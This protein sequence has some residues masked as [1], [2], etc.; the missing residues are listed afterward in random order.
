MLPSGSAGRPTRSTP[1]YGTDRPCW[2]TNPCARSARR[3]SQETFSPIRN[4]QPNRTPLLLDCQV[5]RCRRITQ[6]RK[7][8]RPRENAQVFL[9]R[10]PSWLRAR[11]PARLCLI[12]SSSC[13]SGRRAPFI[14]HSRHLAGRSLLKCARSPL[15]AKPSD[16]KADLMVPVVNRWRCARASCLPLAQ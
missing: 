16:D 8:R 3:Q 10:A 15:A 14:S 4:T 2:S 12:T 5:A 6:Q 11:L 9:D 7:A 1:R 13:A